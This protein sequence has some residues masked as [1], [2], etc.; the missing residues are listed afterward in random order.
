LIEGDSHILHADE[1]S[2]ALGSKCEWKDLSS[3]RIGQRV[4]S[5]VVEAYKRSRLPQTSCCRASGDP[6]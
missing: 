6:P 5:D 4:E 1:E 2:Q 3:I